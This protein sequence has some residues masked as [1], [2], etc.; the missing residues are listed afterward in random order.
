[1]SLYHE[2]AVMGVHVDRSKTQM[3]STHLPLP[4]ALME[5]AS[6]VSLVSTE[7]ATTPTA[8]YDPTSQHPFS[9][10]YSHPTTR[11]SF[12]QHMSE[13]K[14]HIQVYDHDLEAASQTFSSS[15]IPRTTKECSG[16]SGMKRSSKANLC[17][18]KNTSRSPLR[19]LSR[20][21]K[22]WVKILIAMVVVGAA[23]GIGIGISRAV[24]AGVWKSKNS[25]TKIPS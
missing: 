1:M 5:N 13:S 22:L 16:K 24:G 4:N 19:G 18:K 20:K 21:Q 14:T 12:E 11:T 6:D 17:M 10:F 7:P 3:Q 8:E 2:K 9:A 23:V 25:Q 15:D